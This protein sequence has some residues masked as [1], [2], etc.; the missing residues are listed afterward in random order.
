[1]RKRHLAY[2]RRAVSIVT[3]TKDGVIMLDLISKMR[4]ARIPVY[5]M[6]RDIVCDSRFY[7]VVEDDLF[8]KNYSVAVISNFIDS[9]SPDDWKNEEKRTGKK[10]DFLNSWL[11]NH[12]FPLSIEEKNRK[13]RSM[14]LKAGDSDKPIPLGDDDGEELISD[15]GDVYIESGI[16]DMTNSLEK[17]H[18][19][20]PDAIQHYADSS[21]G[22]SPGMR[23]DSHRADADYLLQLD[24]VIVDLAKKIGRSGG[25]AH[26]ISGKFQSASR[27]DISGVTTGNDLNSLLPSELV[28]L[29]ANTTENLFY[30]RYVQKRLQLFSSASRSCKPANDKSGPIYICVDTSGSMEGQPEVTAKTLALSVAIVA[31][32]DKRPICMINYSHNL[33]FFI[34]KDLQWQ[35]KKFLSFLSHSYSGGNDENKLFY[36]IFKKLRS[37]PQYQSF[38]DSFKG[39]DLLIISDFIW[40]HISKESTSLIEN[41][42]NEGMKLYGLGINT[43]PYQLDILD[44]PAKRN[45]EMPDGFN[46]LKECHYRYLCND[47]VVNEYFD[48][49]MIL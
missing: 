26:E 3:T 10:E 23:T 43:R 41:A 29:G 19:A 18:G 24:P 22:N 15:E 33:S 4:A 38:A 7:C 46:F 21:R 47:G 14:N 45:N 36:F 39:A 32:R 16:T 30:Q 8:W 49:Q 1:M 6:I 37:M 9:L 12:L 42:R 2:L 17:I 25:T 27:S 35:R 34:L 13:A 20:L 28:M 48:R 5:Q 44:D 31:Q 40:S 11:A